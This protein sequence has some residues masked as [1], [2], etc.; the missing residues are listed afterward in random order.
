MATAKS[1]KK[2]KPLEKAKLINFKVSDRE[3]A[4]LVLLAKKFATGNLS[5][6]LRNAGLFYKPK[7]GRI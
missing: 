2:S 5:A 1:K 7:S 4:T 3:Y 6:W